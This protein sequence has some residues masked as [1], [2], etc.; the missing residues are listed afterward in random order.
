MFSKQS[1]KRSASIQP[2]DPRNPELHKK[3]VR[4]PDSTTTNTRTRPVTSITESATSNKHV[5]TYHIV[6]R[7]KPVLSDPIA[8]CIAGYMGKYMNDQTSKVILL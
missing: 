2:K 4:I 5:P 1:Q 6:T 3:C 7:N 8:R